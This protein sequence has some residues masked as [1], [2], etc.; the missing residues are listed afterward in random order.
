MRRVNSSGDRRLRPVVR[1]HPLRWKQGFRAH[2]RGVQRTSGP[3]RCLFPGHVPVVEEDDIF[4]QT[5]QG[6]GVVLR[7]GGPARR[8]DAADPLLPK[9]D[10]VHVPLDHQHAALA[11]EGRERL[12]QAVQQG[13]F[14][15]NLGLGGVEV[16]R[17]GVVHRPAPE[18]ADAPPCVPDRED[19]TPPEPI[20][21]PAPGREQKTCRLAPGRVDP[22]PLQ[23]G[24][25]L[26]AHAAP[27][28]RKLSFGVGS[29]TPPPQ[30]LPPGLP[31]GGAQKL[32]VCVC[33]EA[34]NGV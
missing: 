30:K 19:H 5:L 34:E 16:L 9:S 2:P 21:E 22:L 26:T 13:T 8:H 17:D 31:G 10:Q 11:P 27:A 29:H 24:D 7:E 32:P 23:R 3:H 4:R 14:P 15:V 33:R 6:S 28:K 12:V 25:Q 20:P 1:I 18:T